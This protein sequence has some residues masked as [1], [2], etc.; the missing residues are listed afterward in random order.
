MALANLV[1][2]FTLKPKE[3]ALKGL[4]NYSAHIGHESGLYN[5]QTDSANASS[6]YLEY[7]VEPGLTQLLPYTDRSSLLLN[8]G[9]ILR[10]DSYNETDMGITL[11]ASKMLKS[12]TWGLRYQ[13]SYSFDGP[14]SPQIEELYPEGFIF[15]DSL[16]DTI[17]IIERVGDTVI[18]SDNTYDLNNQVVTHQAYEKRLYNRLF[19]DLSGKNLLRWKWSNQVIWTNYLTDSRQDISLKTRLRLV[20]YPWPFMG[21]IAQSGLGYQN[22]SEDY[23]NSVLFEGALQSSFLIGKKQS[24]FLSYTGGRRDYINRGANTGSNFYTQL[25]LNHYPV[26]SQALSLSY[27]YTLFDWLDLEGGYERVLFVNHAAQTKD[28][29]SKIFVGLLG[30]LKLM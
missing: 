5:E 19:W 6:S 3:Q 2:P 4:L 22:S 13:F 14:H 25:K 7:L 21:L 24:L 23:Y 17:K 15:V 27:S 18:F 1:F 16:G 30:S 26:A 29:S 28:K 12:L 8:L 11:S 9:Q 20:Y 10:K